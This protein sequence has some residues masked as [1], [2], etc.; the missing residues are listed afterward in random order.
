MKNGTFFSGAQSAPA[1]SQMLSEALPLN[2]LGTVWR[3]V[4]QWALKMPRTDKK[5][6]AE[7]GKN[8]RLL[9]RSFVL[10]IDLN[11][12]FNS[13]SLNCAV[14]ADAKFQPDL[15]ELQQ[16]K[17]KETFYFYGPA[18][19]DFS[20]PP[21]CLQNVSLNDP[22]GEGS[23]LLYTHGLWWKQEQCRDARREKAVMS[24]CPL[25]HFFPLWTWDKF[26]KSSCGRCKRGGDV[27]PGG[28]QY[29]IEEKVLIWAF[30]SPEK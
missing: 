5:L 23:I 4:L 18:W 12:N 7:I 20:L 19:S 13:C 1:W 25:T 26:Q 21:H 3:Y 27:T 29:G 9:F 8:K 10:I 2:F 14:V 17:S 30:A 16:P 15:M 28:E 11:Y 6:E 24:P 22:S